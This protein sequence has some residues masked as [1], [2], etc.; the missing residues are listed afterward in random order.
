MEYIVKKC[1]GFDAEIYLHACRY[2]RAA[3]YIPEDDRRAPYYTNLAFS[4]EL[5]IKSLDVTIENTFDSEFPYALIERKQILNTRVGGHSTQK[6]FNKLPN[7]L[8]DK[9]NQVCSADFGFALDEGLLHIDSVFVEWRYAYEKEAIDL[10]LTYLEN[11]ADFL[12][13]F[14]EKEI[15]R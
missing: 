5:F 9:M 7:D 4:I 1:R 12:K 8:K 6:M 15:S 14:I 11:I 10:P 3:H 13:S 2:Y